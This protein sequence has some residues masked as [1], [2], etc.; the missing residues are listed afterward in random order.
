MVASVSLFFSKTFQKK[1]LQSFYH[2][3]KIRT[4]LSTKKKCSCREN[5]S[6]PLPGYL[7]VHPLDH[8]SK[9]VFFLVF[10]FLEN[11]EI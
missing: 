9:A 1:F 3:K 11:D 5:F 10:L 6:V 4:K 7:M 8:K 2:E